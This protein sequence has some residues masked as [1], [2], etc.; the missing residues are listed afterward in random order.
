MKLQLSTPKQSINKAYLKEKI[1]RNDIELFKKNLAILLD[2]INENESEEHHK[3]LISD[4]LKDT[5]YKELYEINTKERADLVIHNGKSSKDAAGVILE[6]KKPTN[7]N[8]MI[9]EA[10]PNAKALQEL[11]FYY[12]HERIDN[13]NIDIKQLIVTNIYEWYIIDEVW[14]EKVVFRNTRLKKDFENHKLS[15]NDT[16]FFYESIA[17]PFL[18]SLTEEIPCTKFDI[19]DYAKFALNKDKA[20]DNK[21]IALYKI[22]SPVCLLKKPF[23]NDSNSLD[24]AFYSELLH[25]IGLTETKEGGKKLIERKKDGE[26]NLASLIESSIQQ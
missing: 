4:F 12:L 20:D 26:R 1:S 23:L 21:L 10:K 2:K 7:K 11:I 9:S 6:V 5:W 14:F 8:E 19:R 25:I 17:A 22:L 16:R 15:G 18:D 3:N 13:N 24:K